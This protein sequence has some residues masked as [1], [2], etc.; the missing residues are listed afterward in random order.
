MLVCKL[1][2]AGPLAIA[3]LLFAPPPVAA[4]QESPGG[5]IASQIR[6]QGFRC[7]NPTGA[8]HDKQASRPNEQVWVLRCANATYRV[9]LIPDM[10]AHVERLN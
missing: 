1:F 3:G 8:A 4:Q 5:I 10:A 6:M 9:R 2:S 7:D